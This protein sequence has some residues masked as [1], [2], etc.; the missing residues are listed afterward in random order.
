[1]YLKEL[2]LHGFK[3]FADP[4]RLELER[5]MTAIVGPN[6]CGKSNIA[7]AI[8]WVLGEQ[9]AK[10]LRAGAMQ[11]VIFQGAANR[12]P[13]NLCE[14]TLVFDE[15]ED[16]LGTSFKQVE[17][18]RR[19]VRDG[20][21]DYFLNGKTCRLKDIQRL[22]LDT[23]VG[24][25]SYS[26]M[27]QGQIDQVL[28]SNPSERRSIFEEAAGISKYKAQRR[29]ALNKLNHTDEHLTRVRDVMDEVSR[30]IGSLK[31][32]AAKALRYK[33]IRRRLTR[34]DLAWG[35]RRWGELHREVTEVD[36][37]AAF[38]R[39]Q[40]ARI[41]KDLA[42]AE[43][44]LGGRRQRHNELNQQLQEF[45]QQV[46]SLRGERDNAQSRLELADARQKDIDQRLNNIRAEIRE[47]DQQR[48]ILAE[49]L[50]GETRVKQE[51]LDLFGNS[52][53][54]FQRKTA[55]MAEVQQQLGAAETHFSRSRQVLMAKENS[56]TRLRSNCTTLEVDL[57]T[58]Q[59]RHANLAE[60]IHHLKEESEVLQQD[61]RKLES[62]RAARQQDRERQEIRI[63]ESRESGEQLLRDFRDIQKRIQE[64][65]RDSAGVQGRIGVLEG[66]QAKFEGFSEGAKAILQG[67]LERVAPA[68]TYSLFL[69]KIQ[70]EAKWTHAV[71]ALLGIATDGVFFNDLN[72]VDA[73]A[74]AL[75]NDKLGRASLLF[76]APGSISGPTKKSETPPEIQPAVTVARSKDP[77]ISA[78]LER[79]LAS[80]YLAPSL[81]EFLEFWKA[82]PS[83]AFD[84]VVTP[85][86]DVVDA[87]GMVISGGSR[88]KKDGSFLDR[89]N[90]LKALR[91]ES[92]DIAENREKLRLLAG[93]LQTKLEANE[94]KLENHRALLDEIREELSTLN[95]QANSAGQ[96]RAQNGRMLESKSAELQKLEQSR[97]ES[98]GKL[99]QARGELEATEADIEAQ[100]K[101]IDEAEQNLQEIRQ[102]RE[103]LRESFNEA[104]LEI[105]E[106]RQRLELLDRGLEELRTKSVETEQ[107]K[108]KREAEIR[109]LTEQRAEFDA[110]R[111]SQREKAEKAGETIREVMVRLEK[112][113]ESL[114]VVEQEIDTV[115][116]G[117]ANKREQHDQLAKSLNQLEVQ[118]ARHQSQLEY[119]RAELER[120]YEVEPSQVDWK[121]ELWQAGDALPER[122]KVDIEEESPDDFDEEEEIPPPDESQLEQLDKT[123]WAEVEEEIQNLRSR[124]QA[125]G[126]VNVMAIEEYKD[127]KQRHDFLQDQS[128]DLW[129]AKDELIAAIDEINKTSHELFSTTFD[130]I[131]KNFK[132]TFTTLFGGGTADL[133]LV[134][135]EDILESGIDISAQPPGTRLKTLALL[136]GGQKTMTAVA[137]LF[138]I[139]MVKPSPFCVLDEIDAPLDDANIGRFTAMLERFLEFSQFVIITHNKRT[140]SVADTI[141]GAT[142][143]DK[144][145]TRMVSMRFNKSTG[146]TE[147]LAIEGVDPSI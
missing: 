127:L 53:E 106:K 130:Q 83:F 51:Q 111:S 68:D 20:G 54:I 16:Q 97:D 15:C 126:P 103:Q 102:Q 70:V 37:R 18:S 66:L 98:L 31:R 147:K 25:V 94:K 121:Q 27:L 92:A 84:W 101:A 14:V 26:F 71:E 107:L 60:E 77:A 57:K 13:V 139:Y 23:G 65:E 58:Y 79:F 142:M 1:M 112:H 143:Q 3:S 11:D 117:L 123:D 80:C 34:L 38:L 73:V 62:A 145:V 42:E 67:K 146:K 136:S 86:L 105:A 36:G 9:S 85:D 99:E 41:E 131:R 109:S 116:K 46:F 95:A 7:D 122:I 141:Y 43:S 108:E 87:R 50:A 113:R 5:G 115:E 39:D 21:S 29:E 63:K 89:E 17:V 132:Y 75:R 6:G 32:Q 140:I 22:F 144:G 56:L 40:V 119:I 55:E 100:K 12:K 69:K 93:Q 2:R 24:Q 88:N 44:G 35:A 49:K 78:Y 59:V 110:D 48:S 61:I 104:R 45:Q 19:V 134:D 81:G 129:N 74:N 96:N 124:I 138:A 82:N 114:K 76:D 10:S 137:L 90:Q 91:K 120:E 33:R 125:M 133:T 30:Q 8:R 72:R 28:S 118:L 47:L 135:A 52:D 128:K 4:T 64:A